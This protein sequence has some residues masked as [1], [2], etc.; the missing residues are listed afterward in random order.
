MKNLK[1]RNK[2]VEKENERLSVLFKDI[3][4]TKKKVVE[5]LIIQA[6]RLRVLL[7]DMWIDISENGDYEA[8]SQSKDLDPYER[9]RPIADLYNVRDNSYQKIIKQLIDYLP[10]EVEITKDD[11]I[12]GD[13]LL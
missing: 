9:K 6:S 1:T 13:D 2:L 4:T 8:F 5:G 11:V 3:P 12:K 7:N 10:E